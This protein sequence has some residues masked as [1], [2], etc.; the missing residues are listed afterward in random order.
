MKKVIML[1]FVSLFIAI[2]SAPLIGLLLGYK[3][4]NVEKRPLATMPELIAEGELNTS[5]PKGIEDYLADHY[6]FRPQLVAADAVLNEFLFGES[7][8][9]QVIIG[10]EHWLFFLPTLKDYMKDDVLSDNE[11]YR[12]ARTIDLQKE[13]LKKTGVTFVFT[14]AP[15][16]ASIYPEYMPDRYLMVE[17]ENN[18]EK[19]TKE[20]D[21]IE[22]TYLDLHSVLRNGQGQLYHKLDTHW[23]G[24]GAMMAYRSLMEEVSRV[25]PDFS[26][27]EYSDADAEVRQTWEGDLSDMLYPALA[28]KDEQVFYDMP[29][30]YTSARPIKSPEDL[31]IQTVC[32][33]GNA[34]LLIFRDSFAN[35]LIPMLSNSFST[36]TYSRAIPYDYRLLTENTDVVVFEIAERNLS[37]ILI[38]APRISSYTVD[39]IPGIVQAQI[40]TIM[41]VEESENETRIMGIAIPPDYD[42]QA[43]YDIY[44]RLVGGGE[45]YTFVT[46]PI[47][48]QEFFE[49]QEQ[50]A[51]VAFS[52]RMSHETLLPGEYS[53]EVIV[54][55]N[56]QSVYA[57]C[58]DVLISV[59]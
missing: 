53:V 59:S 51:N 49:G 29:T 30:E 37:N 24:T 1:I 3:N 20:L 11:I 54:C 5:Y 9:S 10:K 50:R 12:M 28:I 16:K 6:A 55:R 42:M 21:R 19:L 38:S 14:V 39:A 47:F 25:L 32:E 52:L 18:F 15:N 41:A 35:A 58:P 44:L 57:Q 7:V 43:N 13:A 56:G 34:D 2:C 4:I 17:E 8:N 22:C 27:C 26:Y 33:N 36:V 46:F 40:E 31:L 45:E 23:N 48:E